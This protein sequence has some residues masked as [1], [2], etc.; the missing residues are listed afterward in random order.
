MHSVKSGGLGTAVLAAPCPLERAAT[1][2]QCSYEDFSM[3]WPSTS[4]TALPGTPPH[5]AASAAGAARAARASVRRTALI[6][7]KPRFV[8]RFVRERR[9]RAWR[10]LG[11]SRSPEAGMVAA[12]QRRP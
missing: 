5:P 8:G 1:L 11:R 2:T 6:M 10:R 3:D 7:R 12:L 4:A 9:A